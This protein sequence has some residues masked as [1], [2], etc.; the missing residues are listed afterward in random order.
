[1]STITS[2]QSRVQTQ[3]NKRR[4]RFKGNRISNE[5]IGEEQSAVYVYRAPDVRWVQTLRE[6][7]GSKVAG[8]DH[9]TG[10]FLNKKL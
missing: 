6:K 8:F 2:R 3:E 7:N 9:T 10:A 5:S 4:K 1:M